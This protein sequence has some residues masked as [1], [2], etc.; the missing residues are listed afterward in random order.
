MLFLGA[1]A[2]VGPAL[3]GELSDQK[4]EAADTLSQR[5]VGLADL[6]DAFVDLTQQ[7]T[8]VDH[9]GRERLEQL[10]TGNHGTKGAAGDLLDRVV[11]DAKLGAQLAVGAC[12]VD[13]PEAVLP[14]PPAHRQQRVILDNDGAVFDDLTDTRPLQL[15]RD[16]AG[17]G[18]EQLANLARRRGLLVQ[19]NLAGYLLDLGVRQRHANRKAIHQLLQQGHV[20]QRA[21]A[22]AN[23]HHLAIELLAHG[24]RDLGHE[25]RAVV[26]F[27]DVLLYLVEDEQDAGRASIPAVELECLFDGGEELFG[28]DVARHRRV[29]CAQRLPRLGVARC[30]ARIASQQCLRDGATDVQVVQFP[31]ECLAGGLDRS[32]HHV[33]VA[34]RMEPQAEACL[35]VLLRKADGPQQDAQDREPDLIGGSAGQ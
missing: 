26:G 13:L 27:A 20:R 12:R 35:R 23:D 32:L 24:L 8:G 3:A 6:D 14:E 17:V 11:D 1:H 10:V 18:V 31:V 9:F 2:D 15:P 22:R 16:F 34:L 28:R 19:Q 5:A 30:V 4:D 33:E 7:H 21:L 25:H 29:A